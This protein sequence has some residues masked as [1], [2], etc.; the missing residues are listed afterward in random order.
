MDPLSISASII[1]VIS[2]AATTGNCFVD[3]RS[4]CKTLPGRLHALSNEVSDLEL[5]LCQVA[6]IV[7]KR[8]QDPILRDQQENIPH[9]LKQAG[10]KFEELTKIVRK[11]T[12]QSSASTKIPLFKLAAWRRDQPRLLALQEEIKTIKCSLNVVLGAS[13]S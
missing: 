9:L 13:N 5:V 8:A 1:A 12:E 11:L 2:L 3:L 10:A 6:A 4:T 7:E